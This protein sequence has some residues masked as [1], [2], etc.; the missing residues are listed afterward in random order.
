M[1]PLVDKQRTFSRFS[2]LLAWR[3]ENRRCSSGQKAEDRRTAGATVKQR[4]LF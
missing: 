1:Q 4:D 3:R 2:F